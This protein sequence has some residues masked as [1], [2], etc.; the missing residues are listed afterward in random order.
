MTKKVQ[1]LLV[2]D[3]QT[4]RRVIAD[5]LSRENYAVLPCPDAE[6]AIKK[7]Q[8]IEVDLILCDWRMPGMGGGGLLSHV[9]REGPACAF[10][11]MTAYGSISHAVEAVRM[12]ADDYL[13]KPFETEALL[14]AV[15]RAQKTHSLERENRALREQMAIKT[16]FG[17]MIGHSGVMERVY[18][19]INKVASTDATVLIDGESGTGKELVAQNLHKLSGRQGPLVALNCAAI[20]ETLMESELF[21]FERGAF[22]GAHKRTLGK[23]EQAQGGTLFLDEIDSL[24]PAMQAKLL[25]VLQEKRLVR[26]GGQTE[27]VLDVRSLAACNRNLVHLVQQGAFRADLFYRLNVVR[28]ELPALRERREDIGPL[29]T[30]FL[31]VANQR[32]GKNVAGLPASLLRLFMAYDWP[33]NVRELG[34]VLERLV[35]LS[36]DNQLVLDELP[37]EILEPTP[38]PGCSFSLPPGGIC[39]EELEADLIRQALQRTGKNRKAAAKLLGLSYKTLLYRIEKH[40]LKE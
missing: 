1:I 26:L 19:A 40:N 13:A 14:L 10:V 18:H 23:F 35:L 31:N 37:R 33:G 11:V 7:L 32:H 12:G 39:L 5:I 2:E 6:S 36:E 3:E 17:S 21:G 20:P 34:N 16:G 25:R 27:V 24:G 29:S 4:Q 15:K 38:Q 30:H 22:T 8:E 28:L 9:R